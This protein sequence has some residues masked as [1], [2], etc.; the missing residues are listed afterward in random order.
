VVERTQ[1]TPNQRRASALLAAGV[2]LLHPTQV[3]AVAWASALPYVL[4]TTMLLG[5]LIAYVDGRRL[6]SIACYGTSLLIRASAFGFPVVLLLLD[7]YPLERHRHTRLGR[8]ALEKVP[9]ALLAGATAIAE[10]RARE[11]ASFREVGLGA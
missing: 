11:I 3:E 4:S 6:V 1:L 7:L 5:A 2:F 9:F 8:L 10:T